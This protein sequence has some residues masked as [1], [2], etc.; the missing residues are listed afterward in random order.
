MAKN[1]ITFY[2]RIFLSLAALVGMVALAEYFSELAWRDFLNS[3]E[4]W[5]ETMVL[6]L[7]SGGLLGLTGFWLI[8]QKKIYS[9]LALSSSTVMG[10]L[11]AIAAADALQI[12]GTF[13]I[14]TGAM[15]FA[16]GL[17]LLF[18]RLLQKR[19]QNDAIT[20]IIYLFA[21]AG[22]I[23]LSNHISH[24]HHEIESHLFG[25]SLSIPR[26]DFKI[27][28]PVF[29]LLIFPAV[30]FYKSW[31]SLTFDPVFFQVTQGKKTKGIEQ[32]LLLF[33]FLSLMLAARNFGIL[34][35]FSLFLFAPLTA[36]HQSK[37]SLMTYVLSGLYGLLIF[38][39]GFLI[40]YFL[41]WPTGACIS[42]TGFVVFGISQ[43]THFPRFTESRSKPAVCL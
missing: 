33:V 34:V 16:L 22:L 17:Y 28:A 25:N 43:I 11:L 27:F 20:A 2:E 35:T 8:S 31:R 3:W 14:E 30:I 39:A 40:S 15:I 1:R 32:S 9:A 19:F 29:G 36:W 37:S 42:A 12:G 6:G 13:F 21:T 41:D 23:L 26:D 18:N 10:F 5:R 38:P 7:V 4:L 24:G